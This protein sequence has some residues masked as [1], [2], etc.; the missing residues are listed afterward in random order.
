MKKIIVPL[1]G[2]TINLK[3]GDLVELTGKI[4]CGRD[5]VLPH[6]VEMA[7]KGTLHDNGI[8]LNGAVIF[9]TAVSCAGV[10]PTTTSK[11]EIENSIIPLSEAGVKFHL[12]KGV[13]Q[14]E[15]V[16]GLKQNRAYFLITPPVTALLTA[17]MSESKVIAYPELGMEAFYEITVEDFPA[18]VAVA[19][20]ESIFSD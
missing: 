20:G 19:D 7:K 13:I 10:A 1:S 16:A 9:H 2:D 11:P 14:K 17:Q 6:I 3:A 8:D 18:I 12:G 15:T 5:T 4:Y